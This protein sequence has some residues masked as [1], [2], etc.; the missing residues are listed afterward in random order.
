MKK[1]IHPTDYDRYIRGHRI[2]RA[3]SHWLHSHHDRDGEVGGQERVPKFTVEISSKS[4]P[5]YTGEDRTLD[6]AGRVERFNSAHQRRNRN[7]GLRKSSGIRTYEVQ[8]W[9]RFVLTLTMDYSPNSRTITDAY[10]AEEYERLAREL[11]ELHATAGDDVELMKMAD[12]D[13][14]RI[15]A[16]Q[17]EIL[18]DI[19]KILAKEKKKS[20]ADRRRARIARRRGR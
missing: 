4:H 16:R 13:A 9:A 14:V 1:D 12:E 5:F 2:R 17:E 19:E 6:K 10:L 8:T 18:A 11:L 15:R 7:V 3:F 20:R